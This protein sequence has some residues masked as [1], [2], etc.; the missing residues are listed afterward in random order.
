MTTVS[1]TSD[2]QALWMLLGATALMLVVHLLPTPAPLER[3]GE[4]IALSADGKTCSPS[5]S[6]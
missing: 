5:P 6:G 2:R 1:E 3:N 4:L